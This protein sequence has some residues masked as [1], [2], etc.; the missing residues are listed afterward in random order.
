MPVITWPSIELLHSVVTTLRHLNEDLGTPYPVV[1]YR[2]K[3]KLHGTNCGVQVTPDGIVA[4]SRTGILT[5]TSD[6]KGFAKWTH[7][8]ASFFSALAPGMTIFGEWAGAGVEPGMAVSAVGG[9]VFAVFAIQHGSGADAQLDYDPARI[10]HILNDGLGMPT[11]MHVLPWEDIGELQI[12]YADPASIE[13][14]ANAMSAVVERVEQEDPW[15]R[16]TFG[17]SGM[18]EGLVFYPEPGTVPTDPEN[19]ARLLWKAKGEKHRTVRAKQAVQVA[20]EIAASIADFVTLV[21]TEARLLQGLETACAGE[22]DMRHTSA[23]IRWVAADVEKETKAELEASGLV[24]AAVDKAI[25]ARAR[26]WLKAKA[27]R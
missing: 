19:L 10:K 24:W 4:Q 18:G 7:S 21:V 17:S 9:K 22:A 3:T 6:L 5:P 8:H 12:S 27:V 14:A 20:P 1:R 25:Q 13:A 16:R 23:F 15:V 2:A 11:N 26:N